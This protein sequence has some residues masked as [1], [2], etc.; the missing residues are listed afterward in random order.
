MLTCYFSQP[1]TNNKLLDH[2]L[3]FLGN[4]V[5]WFLILILILVFIVLL[6]FK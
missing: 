1:I 4:I 6:N 3:Q 2:L 5:I